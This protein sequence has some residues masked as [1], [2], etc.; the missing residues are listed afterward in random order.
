MFA[1]SRPALFQF[2]SASPDQL[3]VSTFCME[4]NH[5]SLS[6][7]LVTFDLRA[8]QPCVPP[9]EAP[10]SNSS[11]IP[12]PNAVNDDHKVYSIAI[13]VAVLCVFTTVTGLLRLYVRWKAR[14]LGPDDYAFVPA[15]VG[16]WTNKSLDTLKIITDG[17]YFPCRCSM[18][19]GLPWLSMSICK[20]VLESPFG[21]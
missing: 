14:A 11:L 9:N 20:L 2:F 10:M 8:F 17:S 18:L 15:L 12:P 16:I 1:P 13:A 19:D 7:R 3:S 5:S 6:Q 21:R 4:K